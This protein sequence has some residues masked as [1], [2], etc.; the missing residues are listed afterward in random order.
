MRYQIRKVLRC[1][2]EVGDND[3]DGAIRDLGLIHD[4]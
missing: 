3:A 2:L 1:I 4:N